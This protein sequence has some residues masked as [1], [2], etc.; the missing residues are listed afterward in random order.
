MNFPRLPGLVEAEFW[1]LRVAPHLMSLV[2]T[3]TN[4]FATVAP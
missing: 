3:Q 2:V 4:P 1:F